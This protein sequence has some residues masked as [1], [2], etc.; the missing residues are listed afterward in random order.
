MNHPR[1]HQRAGSLYFLLLPQLC[2]LTGGGRT[3]FKK[4]SFKLGRDERNAEGAL[5]IRHGPGDARVAENSICH[6]WLA[7]P[8]GLADP[9]APSPGGGL[10]GQHVCPHGRGR[11]HLT[12][13][14]SPGEGLL[15][16]QVEA[17][18]ANSTMPE[19]MQTCSDCY[20]VEHLYTRLEDH[21]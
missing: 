15:P 14:V 9:A 19:K 4:K 5:D 17:V 2:S 12:S 10:R 18:D 1:I 21:F 20:R 16:F 11:Q 6:P 13:T 3:Y 7:C 8:A